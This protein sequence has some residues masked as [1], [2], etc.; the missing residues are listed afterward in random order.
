MVPSEAQGLKMELTYD[1][2]DI[3]L[4]EKKKYIFPA[5]HSEPE[6]KD[7]E[8][9]HTDTKPPSPKKNDTCDPCAQQ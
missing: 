2:G 8:K 1:R 9:H 7:G 6:K 3:T 5:E 4:T